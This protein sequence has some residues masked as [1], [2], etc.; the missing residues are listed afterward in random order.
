[1]GFCAIAGKHHTLCKS[2]HWLFEG[3]YTGEPYSTRSLP[4]IFHRAKE[5]AR[6]YQMVSFRSLRHSCATGPTH[7]HLHEAGTVIKLIKEL[8]G[9]NDLKTT[10]R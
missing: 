3:E 5:A 6:I 7:R 9:H 8:L 4:N 2:Q 1:M 10:L